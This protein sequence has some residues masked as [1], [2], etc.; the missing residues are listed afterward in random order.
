MPDKVRC[1]R[2]LTFI[3]CRMT[4]H[5]SLLIQTKGAIMKSATALSRILLSGTVSLSAY[6]LFFRSISGVLPLFCSAIVFFGCLLLLQIK[7]TAEKAEK[8]ASLIFL[9]LIISV[10][11]IGSSIYLS[12]HISTFF[13]PFHLFLFRCLFTFSTSYVLSLPL[14]VSVHWLWSKPSRFVF[15]RHPKTLQAVC[16]LLLFITYL[17]C[18]LAYDPGIVG[19]DISVQSRQALGFRPVTRFHPPFHTF[20]WAIC[21][22][23]WKISGISPLYI[24]GIFQIFLLSFVLSCFLRS[25][26]SFN[27]SRFAFMISLLFFLLNPVI[28]IF[29]GIMVKDVLFGICLFGFSIVLCYRNTTRGGRIWLLITALLCMLLRNNAFFAFIALTLFLFVFR[30]KG[31]LKMILTLSI[32]AYILINGPIYDAMHIQEGEPNEL[33]SVPVTQI[34]AIISSHPDETELYRISLS[35]YMDVDRIANAFN[36][37]FADPLKN[38]E[39]GILYGEKIRN[40]PAGFLSIWLRLCSLYPET[41]LSAFL[42]LNIQFWYLGAKT[43]DPFA[44]RAFIETYLDASTI[45]INKFDIPLERTKRMPRI[46]AYYESF[47]STYIFTGNILEPLFAYAVPFWFCVFCLIFSIAHSQTS[48]SLISFLLLLLT[49]TFLFGPVC[50]CRYLFF[51]ILHLPLTCL[52]ALNLVPCNSSSI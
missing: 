35:E 26:L 38:S 8:Q 31:H 21:L 6:I 49:G 3:S 5:K 41:A 27:I 39:N 32:G 9:L 25:L 24:Y 40:N 18:F 30:I 46:L 36:P 2:Y 23:L 33:L 50:N 16:F 7:N 10:N 1:H 22:H 52:G 45:A 47:A 4:S 19:Y 44:N 48:L 37:R 15:W 12:H 14:S 42:N 29:A 34:G 51:V 11:L 13:S 20:I 28:A 17:I 43:I